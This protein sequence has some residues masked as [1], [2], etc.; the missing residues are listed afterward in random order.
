MGPSAAAESEAVDF[1]QR[2]PIKPNHHQKNLE[3][4][5]NDNF[6]IVGARELTEEELLLIQGGG[7]FGDAW[8]AVTGAAKDVGH[9]IGSA[10]TS[11]WNFIS[12]DGAQK[13]FKTIGTVAGLI[14]IFAGG[15]SKSPPP[16]PQPQA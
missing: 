6:N 7:F 12:S 16:S 2:R 13:V 8:S 15:S 10:A 9:A 5:M 14:A 11:S 4:D 1:R 3:T